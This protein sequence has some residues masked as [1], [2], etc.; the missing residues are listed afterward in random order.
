MP[1]KRKTSKPPAT[2]KLQRSKTHGQL[3]SRRT[4]P[5]ARCARG[6]DNVRARVLGALL[7]FLRDRE[8]REKMSQRRECGS[9]AHI[10]IKERHRPSLFSEVSMTLNHIAGGQS[11]SRPIRGIEQ[12]LQ[13]NHASYRPNREFRSDIAWAGVL[14]SK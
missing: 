13:G 10:Q 1:R 14:I 11:K 5:C 7:Y 12:R 6:A 8:T 3:P 9:H 4:N 2:H